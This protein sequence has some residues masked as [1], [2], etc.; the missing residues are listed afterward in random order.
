MSHSALITFDI[1]SVRHFVPFDILSFGILSHSTFCRSTFCTFG[2]CYVDIL[3]VN[4]I[5][6]PWVYCP[7]SDIPRNWIQRESKYIG[8]EG[9]LAWNFSSFSTWTDTYVY[10]RQEIMYNMAFY[11]QNIVCKNFVYM[12]E[13]FLLFIF[14]FMLTLRMRPVTRGAHMLPRN[15]FGT[16]P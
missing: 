4:R 16:H 9:N 15:L 8:H 5:L 7:G 6:W 14:F 11:V 10:L 1:L 12:M 3:S 13:V 2:V